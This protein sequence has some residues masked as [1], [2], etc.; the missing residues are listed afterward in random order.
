VGRI[1]RFAKVCI[2][3]VCGVFG[4]YRFILGDR[5][6]VVALHRVLPGPSGEAMTLPAPLFDAL[7][8][9]FKRHFRVVPLR[10]I[11]GKL[12]RGEAFDRE[13][14]ITFD[15]GYADAFEVAMPIMEA[16]GLTATVF[17][18]SGFVGTSTV[19]WWDE[20]SGRTHAFMTWDQA[21]AMQDKGFDMG[22]HSRTHQDLGLIGG[23]QA[24]RELNLSRAELEAGLGRAVDLFAYPY[25]YDRHMTEDNRRLAAKA[26]YRCCC[27]YGDFVE[28][29]GDP[30]RLGRLPVSIW[31]SSPAHLGGDLVV[32]ALR[33]AR[34][35]KPEG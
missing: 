30:F 35:E 23:E 28:T 29:G 21:R 2:G 17:L 4:L 6:L 24:E 16:Q 3:W 7:C 12:E 19:P 25:G 13:M 9:F 26:G 5:A 11:V 33:R 8:R 14:A 15:D 1:T 10:E 20:K 27:G 22:G 34:P 18:V 32:R 31:Y